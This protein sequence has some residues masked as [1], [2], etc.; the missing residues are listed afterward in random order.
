[1]LL[2]QEEIAAPTVLLPVL[3]DDAV[4]LL[5]VPL[6][7]NVWRIF[8]HLFTNPRIELY[9]LVV[10]RHENITPAFKNRLSHLQSACVTC[11]CH[12]SS[13]ST[14]QISLVRIAA[15]SLFLPPDTEYIPHQLQWHPSL[16]M[17]FLA[18]PKQENQQHV[19]NGERV[20]VRVVADIFKILPVRQQWPSPAMIYMYD[21]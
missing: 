19:Y 20:G 12:R 7:P 8:S 17:R 2:R 18:V 21:P 10:Q 14:T 9:L 6:N 11:R 3:K 4:K 5:P 13:R 16:P 1:M 15:S